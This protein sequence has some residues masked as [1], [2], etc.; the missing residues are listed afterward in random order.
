[1]YPVCMEAMH[2]WLLS[3]FTQQ[4]TKQPDRKPPRFQLLNR[5]LGTKL[6]SVGS[7][8]IDLG[9]GDHGKSCSSCNIGISISTQK[10]RRDLLWTRG[11]V[12]GGLASDPSPN[13]SFT[14]SSNSG[15]LRGCNLGATWPWGRHG[16]IVTDSHSRLSLDAGNVLV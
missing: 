11:P 16:A 6:C 7:C 3:A 5:I 9:P 2:D 12:M 13:H 15:R 10:E 1:M 4:A 8:V 14:D